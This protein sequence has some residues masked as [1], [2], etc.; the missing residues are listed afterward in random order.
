M[1]SSRKDQKIKGVE[2]IFKDKIT[3]FFSKIMN[4]IKPQTEESL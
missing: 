3:K 2:G 1:W 4:D